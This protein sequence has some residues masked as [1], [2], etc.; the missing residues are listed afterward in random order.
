MQTN[1][2]KVTKLDIAYYEGYYYADGIKHPHGKG[3]ADFIDGKK[4]KG[5]WR[6]GLMHGE[7]I[8]YYKCKL[9]VMKKSNSQAK[10]SFGTSDFTDSHKF[11][12]NDIGEGRDFKSRVRQWCK[13]S[14]RIEAY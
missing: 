2:R 6:D 14:Q 10:E 1:G 11:S 4:Y 5:E 3:T 12:Q 7:G 13:F 8:L 9:Q